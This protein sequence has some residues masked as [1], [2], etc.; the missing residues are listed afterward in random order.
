MI[1]RNNFG[2][3]RSVI[4]LLSKIFLYPLSLLYGAGVWL[5]NYLYDKKVFKSVR[6]DFPVISIGNLSAGGTGKTPHIEYLL[7]HLQYTYK[8]ATLSRGYGRAS[9]GFLLASSTTSALQIGDEPRQFKKKFPEVAVAVGEDRVLALPRI[10]HEQPDTEVILLDDAFQHRAIR[11]GLC[12]LL[13][14][15]DNLFTRDELLPAGWLREHKHNYHRADIIVVTKCPESLS[16]S[17]QQN[18]LAELKPF[19]YQKVYFSRITYSPLY[20]FY[21]PNFRIELDKSTDVLLVCGIARNKALKTYLESRVQNL[22]VREYKDHHRFDLFDLDAIRE[23]FKNL[24]NSKKII[25][26]T[27]K[28]AARLEEFTE[29]L[30]LNKLDLFVLPIAVEFLDNDADMFNADMVQYIEHIKSKLSQ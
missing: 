20:S 25:V 3:N 13:T 2:R 27:E 1:Q 6:F 30:V 16:K 19:A 5:R 21:N 29:W 4:N 11:A 14:E 18:I 15:H 23:T 26:T 12:V 10:L 7:R 22:Y 17:E 8:V 9:H 24:G 28:D